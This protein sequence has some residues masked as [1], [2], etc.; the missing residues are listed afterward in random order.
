MEIAC[1]QETFIR[2]KDTLN[3]KHY[4][5]YNYIN[6]NTDRASGSSFMIL[7]NILYNRIALKTYLQAITVFGTLYRTKPH[8]QYTY[9]LVKQWNRNKQFKQTM[10]TI[11]TDGRLQ[12]PQD[13]VGKQRKQPKREDH[14]NTTKPEPTMFI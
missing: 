6:K 2:E 5:S 11:Y 4:T 3:I 8:A 7:N 14:R 10:N 13:V 9:H 1:L 12:Q